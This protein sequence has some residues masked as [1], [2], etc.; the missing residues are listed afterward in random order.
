[1]GIIY[2][3][4]P[5]WEPSGLDTLPWAV[6]TSTY[7]V[8][9][10]EFLDAGAGGGFLWSHQCDDGHVMAYGPQFLCYRDAGN[11][12]DPIRRLAH[13]QVIIDG[14][15]ATY[16]TDD[17]TIRFVALPERFEKWITLKGPQRAPDP[18][19]VD[20]AT[21]ML[22]L[23]GGIVLPDGL[24][25]QD[26]FG[27][28]LAGDFRTVGTINLYCPIRGTVVR[29][30]D[31][32]RA[33]DGNGEAGHGEMRLVTDADGS[34]RLF[35]GIGWAWLQ[36][37][38]FP[39]E[40]DPTV[41]TGS[42]DATLTGYPSQ[43]RTLRMSNGVEVVLWQG[44]SGTIEIAVS[45]DGTWLSPSVSTLLTGVNTAT[46]RNGGFQHVLRDSQD[47][48][49][50]I[51]RVNSTGYWYYTRATP[52]AGRTAWTP[53]AG[54]IIRGSGNAT[55]YYFTGVLMENAGAVAVH[56]F[57]KDASSTSVRLV[58]VSLNAAGART[59]SAE[60]QPANT[61]ADVAPTV[62]KL[63]NTQMVL[64]RTYAATG[65]GNGVRAVPITWD[66]GTSTPTWGTAEIVTEAV[67][68]VQMGNVVCDSQGRVYVT[69]KDNAGNVRVFRRP[70]SGGTWMDVSPAGLTGDN[71]VVGVQTATDRVYL[72]Y[73]NNGLFV[74]VYDGTTPWLVAVTVDSTT[75]AANPSIRWDDA[76]AASAGSKMSVIARL[77]TSP[78]SISIYATPMNQA[79]QAPTIT[80]PTAF[81]TPSGLAITVTLNDPDP[82]DT[83]SGVYLKRMNGATVEWWNGTAWVASEPG[84]PIAASGTSWTATITAGWVAGTS[85]PLYAATV[86]AGGAE[87]PYNAVAVIT[88]ASTKPAFNQANPLSGSTV[89]TSKVRVQGTTTCGSGA[90]PKQT[91]ARLLAADGTTQ[92]VAPVT[93][94]TP[95][96]LDY[97]INYN[98]TTGTGYKTGVT[99]IDSDGLQGDELVTAYTA[100]FTAPNQPTITA[101]ADSSA[102][103]PKVTIAVTNPAGGTA[104]SS[105]RI[106]RSTDNAHWTALGACA[107][108]ASLDDTHPASGQQYYYRAA[109]IG[110]NGT[111][112]ASAAQTATVTRECWWFVPVTDP[113]KAVPFAWNRA[114]S[115]R[116]ERA[117]S[118]LDTRGR[119]TV[120]GVGGK[121]QFTAGITATFLD[122]SQAVI[123]S[124]V[125]LTR[126]EW[127]QRFSDLAL[128]TQ[129][130]LCS[131]E[132][133][134]WR[135]ILEPPSIG[136]D[137]DMV[138]NPYQ[139]NVRFIER[140]VA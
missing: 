66:W 55:C 56:I 120:T 90:T 106:E 98:Q 101:T 88:K 3:E 139:I 111:E 94:D 14:A 35:Q 4:E 85:Y 129:G 32:M 107:A 125:S 39:V 80:V 132:G 26:Q 76:S 23:T 123:H 12:V 33:Q 128:S 77:G 100:T 140:A 16:D 78:Y 83:L 8:Y 102:F 105:N 114:S 95:G 2:R 109:A 46:G 84:A 19:L 81:H 58:T 117:Y 49:H 135:G 96:A 57:W 48:L 92:L 130:Y 64:V 60:Y 47:N 7:T 54:T 124:A 31:R 69:F 44:A 40:I 91:K 36:V 65:I 127:L 42:T 93:L 113:T 75:T 5:R 116:D 50:I 38:T 10:S 29:F 28:P 6:R 131:P 24:E 15:T 126:A 11:N 70:A 119:W 53:E 41:V 137:R 22:T 67:Y 63:S 103:P 134:V 43:Q 138:M 30:L 82:G 25:L 20:P 1:M 115:G 73:T 110:D 97:T 118:H 52:N 79:P 133:E 104:V 71:P 21:A 108:N 68:A 112:T 99:P 86:D 89:N 13:V 45:A 74:R 61:P 9:L 62:V 17:Y 121:K 59:L 72:Y 18:E 122:A 37:A 51:Y 27:A 87:G 34:K 136:F